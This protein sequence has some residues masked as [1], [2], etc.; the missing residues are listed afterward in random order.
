[1]QS[2]SI[3]RANV[4]ADPGNALLRMGETFHI[5]NL[6]DH[7]QGKQMLDAFVAAQC[8]DQLTNPRC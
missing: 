6:G 8:L 7:G 3:C 2:G 4:H 5:A 1:M